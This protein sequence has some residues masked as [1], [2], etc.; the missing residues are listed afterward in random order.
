[1]GAA[2]SVL[3]C[4]STAVEGGATGGKGGGGV[5][6]KATSGSGGGAA[7]GGGGAAG[8]RP[9]G[10]GLAGSSS[11][12]A[13]GAP[14]LSCSVTIEPMPGPVVLASRLACDNGLGFALG[15]AS[16][17]T[18]DLTAFLAPPGAPSALMA[19]TVTSAGGTTTLLPTSWFGAVATSDRDH[20]PVNVV[21]QDT[22]IAWLTPPAAAGQPFGDSPVVSGLTTNDGVSP[23]DAAVGPDGARQVLVNL[24]KGGLNGLELETAPSATAAFAATSVVASSMGTSVLDVDGSGTAHV[25]YWLPGQGILHWQP[26]GAAAT[27]AFAMASASSPPRLTHVRPVGG[28]PAVG[29]AGMTDALHVLRP[30]ADGSLE[31]IALANSGQTPSQLP[32]PTMCTSG[33]TCSNVPAHQKGE[34][35]RALALATGQAG[36]LWIATVRDHLDRDLTVR[37]TG[38]ACMCTATLAT[39][40]STSSLVVQLLSPGNS[41]PSDALWTYDL[42]PG[43]SQNFGSLLLD[44][45]TDAGYLHL[46]VGN[47]KNVGARTFVIDLALL[48]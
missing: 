27:L 41:T 23:V 11:G 21:R 9:G 45:T 24:Y 42:G 5:G 31:N 13:G 29:V 20:R 7:S 10:G 44:A 40:R 19:L 33:T 12:G 8:G 18:A 15:S 37:T 48:R 47:Q 6:G 3:A 26:G 38:E 14:S 22:R 35:A 39:D 2:A 46:L 43:A 1:L 30:R 25:F 17:T 4:S 28:S 32:F 36:E 16:S 34:F